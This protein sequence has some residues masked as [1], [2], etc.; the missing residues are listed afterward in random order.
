MLTNDE[1]LRF[2]DHA[3]KHYH[4]ILAVVPPDFP[5]H[6]FNNVRCVGHASSVCGISLHGKRPDVLFLFHGVTDN[7]FDSSLLPSIDPVKHTIV[8]LY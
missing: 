4:L 6:N 8:R 1:I 2:L 3:S 5:L 7:I